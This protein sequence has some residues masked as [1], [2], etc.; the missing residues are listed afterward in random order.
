MTSKYGLLLTAAILCGCVQSGEEVRAGTRAATVDT[1]PSGRILVRNPDELPSAGPIWVLRERLRLGSIGGDGADVFGS[2]RDIELGPEGKFYVLDEHADE[3]RAFAPDGTHLRTLGRSG[4][5]PGELNRPAGI[6]LGPEGNLWV[7][8]WGNARHTAFNPQT[9]EVVQEPRRLASF[10]VI[11]WPGIFDHEG[12]LLDVGL[13]REGDQGGDPALLRLDASFVPADTL[14]MP[15]ADERWQVLFKRGDAQIMSTVAPFAPRPHWALRAAGGIIVGEGGAYRLHRV[16]F[17]S[18]TVMT[19][20]LARQPAPVTGA[21]RDSALA[22]FRELAAEFE[23]RPEREPRVPATKPAHG[24][25][26]VD[27][28]DQTWVRRTGDADA[29]PVWDIFGSDGHLLGHVSAPVS[30]TAI[31]PVVRGN[32]L[33]VVS[34]PNGVP[35]VVVFDIVKADS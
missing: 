16:G 31:P 3:V 5:G 4:Q 34:E 13:S 30:P 18:D 27:D 15:R 17:D 23:A 6:T 22:E 24:A 26:F 28:E 2:I 29:D 8:N 35:T 14:P 11:P 19:I 12:R 1:L 20:E 21:E 33:A 7:M 9:G 10:A 25:L 32:R